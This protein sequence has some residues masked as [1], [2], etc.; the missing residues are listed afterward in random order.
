[1]LCTLIH[2]SEFSDDYNKIIFND[3]KILN[4][5]YKS[6]KYLINNDA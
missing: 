5:V 3:T 4:S 6:I 1:M 2:L